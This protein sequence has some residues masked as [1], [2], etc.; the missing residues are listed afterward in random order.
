M[1]IA[2]SMPRHKPLNARTLIAATLFLLLPAVLVQGQVEPSAKG[3]GQS[4]WIGGSFLN[5][6]PGFP[7]GSD[8]R[9]S[10]IGLLGQFNWTRRISL[11][12]SADFLRFS[13][14]HGET[15]SSFL[16]GPRYTFLHSNTW[17]PYARLSL[18]AVKVHFPFDIGDE[19]YFTIAPAGGLEYRLNRRWAMH[20]EYQ[21]R[22]LLDSPNFTNE[23]QYGIH[24][25]GVQVGV[26][27]RIK[28]WK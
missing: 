16:V 26:T 25:N 27:Y 28:H 18:G 5:M 17:R 6:N 15:Q 20:T 9:M 13:S 19:S 3:S 4:V 14:F 10:G 8:L 24:P 11:D 22:F 23:P 7:N 1:F 2:Q 21:Y 12:A